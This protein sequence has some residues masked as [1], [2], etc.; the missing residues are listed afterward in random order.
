MQIRMHTLYIVLG[1]QLKMLDP[2]SVA[3]FMLSAWEFE[4]ERLAFI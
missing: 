3:V 4:R 2:D 1:F